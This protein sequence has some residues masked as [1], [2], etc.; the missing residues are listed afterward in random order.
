MILSELPRGL[1]P[2]G[3]KRLERAALAEMIRVIREDEPSKPS[4]R[5]ST[6]ESPPSLAA[7]R[8]TEPRTLACMPREL[9]WVLMSGRSPRRSCPG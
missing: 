1:R 5:L 7:A 3:R 6:D 2:I 9:D 8:K 4:T